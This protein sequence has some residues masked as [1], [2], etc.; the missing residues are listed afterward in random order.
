MKG[1]PSG[2]FRQEVGKGVQT[3]TDPHKS[4]TGRLQGVPQPVING[5]I[6]PISRVLTLVTHLFS[7]I[8]RGR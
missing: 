2:L 7:A 4:M 6:T 1:P 5:V 8:S 3:N